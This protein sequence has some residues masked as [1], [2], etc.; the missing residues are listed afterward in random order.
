MSH[1]DH[2]LDDFSETMSLLTFT[3]YLVLSSVLHLDTVMKPADLGEGVGHDGA[4]EHQGVARVLLADGRL[5]GEGGGRAVNLGLG[6]GVG[7]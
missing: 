5:L 3:C 1:Y 2:L 6:G 4:V 7:G